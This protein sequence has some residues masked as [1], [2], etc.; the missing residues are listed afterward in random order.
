MLRKLISGLICHH[1]SIGCFDLNDPY[2]AFCLCPLPYG[3]SSAITYLV[4]CTYV[5]GFCLFGPFVYSLLSLLTSS[6]FNLP[7]PSS[8]SSPLSR[9]FSSTSLSM[10]IP[11][12]P[13]T[14]LSQGS[15]KGTSVDTV[16]RRSE[17]LPTLMSIPSP[18]SSSQRSQIISFVLISAP[19]V[20]GYSGLEQS[21]V[22]RCHQRNRKS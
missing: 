17:Y 13:P 5:G 1:S 2:D 19:Y 4:V 21:L 20:S 15:G 10:H 6:L 8:L 14:H 7:S 3:L 12:R 18:L 9:D 22:K 11:M 16:I